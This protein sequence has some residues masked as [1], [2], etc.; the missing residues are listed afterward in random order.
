MTIAKIQPQGHALAG[1]P[2]RFGI[3]LLSL[4][5]IS[6]AWAEAA[7]APVA[8]QQSTAPSDALEEILVTAR[9]QTESSLSV[10]VAVSAVSGADLTRYAITDVSGIASRIPSVSFDKTPTGGSGSLTIRGIGSSAFDSAIEQA[11]STVV[12]GVQT[13]RG[14]FIQSGLLDVAGIEVLEGPQA[15]FFGKNSPAGVLSLTSNGPTDNL[16]GY[17]RAGYGFRAEE[18]T[19][20]AAISGPVTDT[21]RARVAVG[22]SSMVGWMHNRAVPMDNPFY[23]A[24]T[25]NGTD[26][27][28]GP[29]PYTNNYNRDL[30]GR[31]TVDYKPTEDFTATFRSVA[32]DSRSNG[33]GA[34]TQITH[35]GSPTRH[36]T[37]YGV[38]D[39]QTNCGIG[40]T[41][42][43]GAIPSQILASDPTYM[44]ANGR[45]YGIFQSYL[46]ALTLDYSRGPIDITSVTGYLNYTFQRTL[47]Y[48]TIYDYGVGVTEEGYHQFSEELRAVTKLDSPV[49]FSAGLFYESSSL[50]NRYINTQAPTPPDP[51]TGSVADWTFNTHDDIK[52]YSAFAQA[53]WNIIE[54]VELAAGARYSHDRPSGD[55][56]NSFVNANFAPGFLKEP[57]IELSGERRSNN[58][59]PEVTLSWKPVRDTLIYGSF[60]TGY[61]AGSGSSTA[62]LPASFTVDNFFYAPEKIRGYEIGFKTLQLEDK[63]RITAAAYSYKYTDLQISNYNAT[64][65]VDE[66]LNVGALRSQGAELAAAYRPMRTLTLNAAV[67]YVHAYYLSFPGIGCFPGQT[68]AQGC[69]ADGTQDLAGQQKFRSPTW[70]GNLNFT[71]DLPAFNSYVVGLSGAVRFSASYFSQENNNPAAVQGAYHIF[72]A[73]VNLRPQSDR[74]QLDL[75]GRNLA[76]KQYVI[77]SLDL[78][79]GVPGDIVGQVSRPREV[80]L[81]GTFRF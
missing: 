44:E 77:S 17:A 76:N 49:N 5:P 9:K 60:K 42:I 10:P 63:L 24:G 74:W 7:P 65:G 23:S 36:P 46:N 14:N 75:I 53:R 37:Q 39:P 72:D 66:A 18:K 15:L 41:Q 62:I 26:S 4:S 35:C 50:T 59:S 56:F 1:L 78:P 28:I 2:A 33:I 31:L 19:F 25:N 80:M 40:T 57:G 43:V 21:L 3:G 20:E 71:Y 64:T 54:T 12:D 38:L 68:L 70:T 22:G 34:E 48:P 69:L 29:A 16:Q 51:V 45:P 52:S 8:D 79:N 27:V 30:M 81:Q 47:I 13:S 61:K 58:V 73:S 67:G 32:S 11:V 55:V 6:L